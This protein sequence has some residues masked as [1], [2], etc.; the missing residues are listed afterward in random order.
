[1]E[2]IKSIVAKNLSDLR[3]RNGMTQLELAERLNYSDKTISKW[4]R[5]ESSPDIAVL[6]EIADLFGVTVDYLVTVEHAEDVPPASA[7]EK[8]KYN[9]KAIAYVSESAGWMVAIFAFIIATLILRKMAFQYLFFVYALPV[10]LTAR[11]VFNSVWFN[12]RHNY[13]I[14]SLLMWSL[15]AA[16]HI[17]FLYFGINVALVYLLG[18][19]G[20]IVI[21]LW[22]FIN[23]PESK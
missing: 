20:Q 15:L 11:L 14:V 23:K 12:R 9:R 10:V 7:T 2:D 22:S 4:E 1:M 17:T 19:A 16:V 6:V 3:Q 5:A 8:T 13:Y 18:I 21:I